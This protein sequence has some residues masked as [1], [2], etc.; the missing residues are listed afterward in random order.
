MNFANITTVPKKGSKLLLQNERGIFRV[1]VVRSILMRLI[2]NKKYPEIDYLMSDCQM[3]GRKRKSCKNNIFILN[4]LIHDVQSSKKKK[5][6]LLQFYDYAQMFDSI[7]LKEAISD[8]YNT[9]VNDDNLELI[10]KANDEIH[11]AVKTDYGLS[12]RQIIRNSVLQGD[13]WGSLLASV[14]VEKIG[15]ECIKDGHFYLYKNVLPVGFLGL[16]DDVVGITEAGC[17]AQMLNSFINVKSAEKNLQFGASKC[18]SILVGKDKKNIPNSR[19]VVDNWNISHVENKKTGSTDLVETYGGKTDVEQVEEYKYLGF[20]ISSTGDNMAQIRNIKN[21]SIG[22]MNRIITKLKS[23]NLR[24]FYYECSKLFMN[25]MLRGSILYSSEMFYNLKEKELRQIERIEE[26]FM[27]KILNTSRGCPITQLYLEYGQYPARFDIQKMRLLYLKYILEQPEDSLIKKFY[28]LQLSK[29]TRGDWA[30]ACK[31][32]LR[33]LKITLSNQ[34]IQKMTKYKFTS[35]IKE[36]IVENALNYLK[37]KQSKKGGKIEYKNIEMAEY[38]QPTCELEI[39]EKQKLFEIRNDMTNI[40]SNFG[41]E[42]QCLCGEKETMEH[43]YNCIYW[44][45]TTT[46]KIPYNKIYNGTIEKQIEVYK[47]FEQNLE[48]RNERMK[49]VNTHVIL[50][51]STVDPV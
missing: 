1:P 20:I 30:S 14:Q 35:L 23:L 7:N 5:P 16:V 26:E 39:R 19:L 31:E 8:L 32:D 45:K 34:E 24:K 42:K 11:M 2:Y 22:I 27:R 9:G 3:G 51:G 44:N 29:P 43:I 13:T 12:D 6:I 17:R 48:Q 40:P 37:E 18:K 28:N 15:Q 36:R 50:D 46:Q 47:T 4:G 38:L 33:A 21:K 25:V 49:I 10:F 41:N